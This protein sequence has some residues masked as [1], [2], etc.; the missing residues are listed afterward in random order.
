MM[1]DLP[2]KPINE[3]PVNDWLHTLANQASTL[4]VLPDPGSP[5]RRALADSAVL[6]IKDVVTIDLA[7]LPKSPF[8]PGKTTK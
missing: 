8:H 2:S 1:K 6:M 4:K 7:I 5:D 3:S